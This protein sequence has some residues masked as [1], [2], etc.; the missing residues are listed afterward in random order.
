MLQLYRDFLRFRQANLADRHRGH[1]QVDQVS[2][3]AIAIRYRRKSAGSILIVVQIMETEAVI[4]QKNDLLRLAK[5]RAWELV[6]ST[7]DPIYGGK[8]KARFDHS[9]NKVVLTGPELIVFCE[10]DQRST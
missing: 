4:E 6:L 5:G 3:S 2:P 7:N 8:E 9:G 1:W 10:Q